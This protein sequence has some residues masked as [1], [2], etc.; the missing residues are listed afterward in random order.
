MEESVGPDYL[1]KELIRA[2]V[3]INVRTESMP[4]P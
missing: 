3:A 2:E 4:R 1:P